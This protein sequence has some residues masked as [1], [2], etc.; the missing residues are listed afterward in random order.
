MWS[1][2][3]SLADAGDMKEEASPIG[4]ISRDIIRHLSK[5][6]LSK[7]ERIKDIWQKAAGKKFYLHAQPISFRR[8]RLVV[9]VDSSSWLYE[10]TMRKEKIAARL[11][12]MLREDFKEL[13]FRIGN[14][15]E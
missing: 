13:Q 1:Y 15:E 9:S 14:P 3:C 7:E 8:K 12:R 5:E 2:P 6:R 11:K 10:L 4:D